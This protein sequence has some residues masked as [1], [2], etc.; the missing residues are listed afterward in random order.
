MPAAAQGRK[1]SRPPTHAQKE[2]T[3]PSICTRVLGV[4]ERYGDTGRSLPLARRRAHSKAGQFNTRRLLAFESFIFKTG[5]CGMS[6]EGA[7]DVWNLFDEWESD[8]PSPGGRARKL[9]E[10][11][12]NPHAMR[13]ALADD[14]DKAVDSDAWYS[15]HLTELD[16]TY[17]AYYRAALPEI[18]SALLGAP[19]VRYWAKGDE[20]EGPSDCRETPFDGD[21]FRLC[22]E[23]VL[24]EH[25]PDAFVVGLYVYSDSCVMSGSGGT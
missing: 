19:K 10:Y 23:Q 7:N 1:R 22:E 15:C 11:F 5:G 13:Q 2:R 16:E 6:A 12:P 4:Y 3:F 17:E 8:G 24:R 18:V 20:N 9:R 25:G 14:I 21:A